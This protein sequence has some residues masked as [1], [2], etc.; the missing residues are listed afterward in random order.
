MSRKKILF[1]CHHFPPLIGGSSIQMGNVLA[2]FARTTINPIY[3]A[4]GLIISVGIIY[5]LNK[6]L[7]KEVTCRA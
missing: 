6:Y 5:V 4:S 2:P 7:H 1:F 3:I